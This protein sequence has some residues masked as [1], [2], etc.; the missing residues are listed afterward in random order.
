MLL[1]SPWTHRDVTVGEIHLHCVEMGSGDIVLLLH[2]F[3][4]FWYSWRRQ[5]PALAEAGFHAVA[6]DLRG[7][8]ESDKPAKV[9]SYRVAKL[10]QDITKLLQ[11]LGN[12]PAFVVGHDWGG[13]LAWRLAALHPEL[14]RKLAILNAPHPAAFRAELRRNPGQWL[15][16]AYVLFFQLPGLPEQVLRARDFA[17]LDR[18]W[19]RQPIH[20]DAFTEQDIAAYKRALDRP[21]GLTGPLNYYRASLRYPRDLYG[22][23]QTILVPT[24][25]LWGEQDLYLNVGLTEN[26]E[27]WVPDLRVERIRDASHWVQNDVPDRVNRLLIDFFHE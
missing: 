5:I 11:Q 25:L 17:L 18:A 7:Y 14:V 20:P 12:R 8:N 13:L 26:L 24:L 2:G 16:S 4:E 22:P 19:H 15:R 27:R 23:P 3:P 9:A 21:G 10:V 1:S 6:P